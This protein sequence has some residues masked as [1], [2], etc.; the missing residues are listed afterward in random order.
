MLPREANVFTDQK[1]I[2][3][4][5]IRLISSVKKKTQDHS[6][7]HSLAQR[8]AEV[9]NHQSKPMHFTFEYVYESIRDLIKM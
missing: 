4:A 8:S 3:T 5:T 6:A 2:I 9:E 7:D 1:S